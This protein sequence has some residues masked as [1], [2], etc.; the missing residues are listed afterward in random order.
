MKLRAS[1]PGKVVLLGEYAVLFG[2][3]ALVRAV[4]RRAVVEIEPATRRGVEV[5]APDVH[6]AAVH[7]E[8]TDDG[9]PRWTQGGEAAAAFALVTGLL[10]GLVATGVLRPGELACR[11]RLDTAAFFWRQ[12]DKNEKLGLGS[13]AA[14]TVAL[15]S[16]LAHRAG[17]A[18]LLADRTDWLR[19]LLR[20]H[21]DF[22]SGRGSGLD[23][24]ASLL[25]G[26]ID[27]RLDEA[28]HPQATPVQWPAELQTV[29]V[30]SGRSASTSRF[31]ADL[32]R[33]RQAEPAAAADLFTALTA[34]ARQAECAV[35][36]ADSLQ[37]MESA[38]KYAAL[39]QALG[40]IAR[41][42]IFTAEH[43][44]IRN[45]L[46]A[47]AG[48]PLPGVVYKPCGAGGGDLGMALCRGAGV[49]ERVRKRLADAG[50]GTVPL[51]EDPTGLCIETV[52]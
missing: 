1:A 45:A 41:I 51:N 31:L 5:I 10:H 3:P 52:A 43:L 46:A 26:V 24:A 38:G 47:S 13:S 17:R 49:A 42:P 35:Q 48:A 25:G 28:G 36:L 16:A 22:Q 12:G 19:L 39:L 33:W 23:V 15:A 21:R 40:E 34:T 14:L 18:D 6:D 50:F 27:Y 30:W 44:A 37:V 32:E 11:L 29:M 2:A 9:Q 20:L 7:F 8:L 4:D